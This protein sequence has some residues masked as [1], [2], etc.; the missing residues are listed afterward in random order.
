MAGRVVTSC[1]LGFGAADDDGAEAHLPRRRRQ[2]DPHLVGARGAVGHRRDLADGAGDR[3]FG[4]SLQ[5][6]LDRHAGRRTR[7]IRAGDG[8]DRLALGIARDLDHHLPGLHDLPRI[9]AGRGDD[10]VVRGKQLGVAELV[11]GD[12]KIRFGRLH[13]RFGAPQRLQRFVVDGPRRV[14]LVGEDAIA[15]LL[16][17]PPG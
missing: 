6:Y 16:R 4:L 7:D 8:E 9:R 13:R 5:P 3:H 11:L 14:A 10:A 12:A 2:R 1:A 17:R 15:F